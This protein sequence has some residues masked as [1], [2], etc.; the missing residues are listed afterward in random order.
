MAKPQTPEPLRA[1]ERSYKVSLYKETLRMISVH[2]EGQPL[3]GHRPIRCAGFFIG[4]RV[5]PRGGRRRGAGPGRGAWRGSA[6]AGCAA[7][8]AGCRPYPPWAGPATKAGRSPG[9]RARRYRRQQT[10]CASSGPRSPARRSFPR[11]RRSATGADS[12]NPR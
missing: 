3:Y 7:R 10:C 1:G 4:R 6:S 12:G 11:R 5:R 2:T 8:T 9:R